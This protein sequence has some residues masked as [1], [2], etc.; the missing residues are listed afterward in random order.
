[1]TALLLSALLRLVQAANMPDR[2]HQL[3]I[4]GT[5]MSSLSNTQSLFSALVGEGTDAGSSGTGQLAGSS[6]LGDA[7]Q[8]QQQADMVSL[9]YMQGRVVELP[10]PDCSAHGVGVSVHM[11]KQR[12]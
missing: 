11:F 2:L 12:P 6:T 4:L 3:A 10:C 8:Q 5:S 7:Q 1:M 9:A